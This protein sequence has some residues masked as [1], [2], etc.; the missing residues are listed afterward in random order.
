MHLCTILH[1][2]WGSCKLSSK[3]LVSKASKA[4][5]HSGC[6]AKNRP[7]GPTEDFDGNNA[8][9]AGLSLVD[10]KNVSGAGSGSQSGAS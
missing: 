4:S 5:I 3:L 6:R 9:P 2:N 10:V 8:A 1:T 7:R